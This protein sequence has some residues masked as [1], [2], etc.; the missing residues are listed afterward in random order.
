MSVDVQEVKELTGRVKY[1]EK[2][3]DELE[4]ALHDLRRD[5]DFIEDIVKDMR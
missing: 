1:L 3:V 4:L 2:V 5:F